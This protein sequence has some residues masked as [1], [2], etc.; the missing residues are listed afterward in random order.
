[1]SSAGTEGRLNAEAADALLSMPPDE[2]DDPKERIKLGLM[3]MGEVDE[4]ESGEDEL[5]E[6]D[7]MSSIAHGELQQHRDL[8]QYA[9]IAA[10]E[11]PLLS[12]MSPILLP[13]QIRSLLYGPMLPIPSPFLSSTPHP[14]LNSN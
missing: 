5:F 7:D 11:M 12:S 8:R 6:G 2:T 13:L 4:Y 10:W 14:S 1:M 9:R 3:S